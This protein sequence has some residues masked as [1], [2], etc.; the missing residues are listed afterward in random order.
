MELRH[1]RYFA[2]VGQAL[3]FTRAALRLRVSQP[4]PDQEE[5]PKSPPN[6][7]ADHYKYAKI[8]PAG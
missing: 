7:K 1:L 5:S 8:K 2:A 3:N 6:R 4:G